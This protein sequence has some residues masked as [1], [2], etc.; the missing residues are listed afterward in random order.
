MRIAL[1]WIKNM[2]AVRFAE[3]SK[4]FAKSLLFPVIKFYKKLCKRM[5]KQLLNSVLAKCR[6]LSVPLT[7]IICICLR[8]RQISDFSSPKSR[9]FARPRPVIDNYQC[10][11]T[12]VRTRRRDLDLNKS[13]LDSIVK[14]SDSTPLDLG[15]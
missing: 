2:A 9:Y 8:P 11:S 14:N 13:D 10:C 7:S 6:D 15:Y 1:S 4:V 3:Q 12:R 5:I